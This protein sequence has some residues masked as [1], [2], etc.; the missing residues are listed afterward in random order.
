MHSLPD[1]RVRIVLAG[2][3]VAMGKGEWVGVRVP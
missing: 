1:V 2:A 3:D